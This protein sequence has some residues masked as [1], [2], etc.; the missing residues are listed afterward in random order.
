MLKEPTD[1]FVPLHDHDFICLTTFQY[2]GEPIA[3]PLRFA[4]VDSKLYVMTL[5]TA[6]IVQRIHENAQ[7]E[8][9]PCTA[10]GDLLGK[11]LEGMAIRL[12]ADRQ[13]AARQAL[14]RKYGWHNRLQQWIDEGLRNL[15]FCCL[16]ITPM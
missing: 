12:P 10:Q 1:G 3:T 9:A 13:S 2:D 11:P 8:V 5:T 4:Q 7:V 16:E 15:P 6:A 14:N